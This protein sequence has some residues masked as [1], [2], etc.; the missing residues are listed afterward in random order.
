[1]FRYGVSRE[2]FLQVFIEMN[3]SKFMTFLRKKIARRLCQKFRLNKRQ[4]V[5]GK[6]DE[7]DMCR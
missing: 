5:D 4:Y 2:V 1:M 7:N 6:F 3:S